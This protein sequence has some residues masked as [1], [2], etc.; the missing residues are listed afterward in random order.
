MW[1]TASPTLESA[2]YCLF[3]NWIIKIKLL[4][5]KPEIEIVGDEKPFFW[6]TQEG[7][8]SLMRLQLLVCS[9]KFSVADPP[10]A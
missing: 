5:E 3:Q 1:K 6:G 7:L 4:Q 2:R 8:F 9:R 10:F